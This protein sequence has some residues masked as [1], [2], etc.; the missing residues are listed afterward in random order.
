MNNI[1]DYLLL[2]DGNIVAPVEEIEDFCLK[3]N[4]RFL[5]REKSNFYIYLSPDGEEY[6]LR[7]TPCL[8]E[9][10]DNHAIEEGFINISE[11]KLLFDDS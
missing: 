4:C 1:F 6:I 9:L 3:I 5:E 2:G 8:R 11:L 10:C 7:I